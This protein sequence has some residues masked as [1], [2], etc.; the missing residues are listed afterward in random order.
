MEAAT[1]L[2]ELLLPPLGPDLDRFRTRSLAPL[3]FKTLSMRNWLAEHPGYAWKHGILWYKLDG[4]QLRAYWLIRKAIGKPFG[5]YILNWARR[6]GKT[7]ILLLIAIEE[8]IRIKNSRFNV[9]A[10]TKT[11]LYEFIWPMLRAMI[12]DC[13]DELKPKISQNHVSFEDRGGGYLVL[14]GCDDVEAVER[15]RGPFSHG[16]II[17]EGGT[18]PAKPGLAY[19]ITSILSPQLKSTRGWTLMAMTPPKSAGHASARMAIVAEAQGPLSYDYCTTF[20]CPRYDDADH[21]LSMKS[22]ADLL[23]ITIEEYIESVDFRRE[24]LALIETDPN[25]AIIRTFTPERRKKAVCDLDA[26]PIYVDRYV[27]MDIGFYPDFTAILYAYWSYERQKLRIVGERLIRRMGTIELKNAIKEDEAKFFGGNE[28]FLR[29]ADNN[30]KILV[31]DLAV[32]HGLIFTETAKDDLHAAVANVNMW[33]GQGRI[34][35]DPECKQLVAQMIAGTWNDKGTEFERTAEFGHFD[36]IASLVYLVR[37]VIPNVNR[38]PRM[39]GI[40][41]DHE[42]A[43]LERDDANEVLRSFFGV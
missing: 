32:D 18:I 27:S 25:Y 20:D 41:E 40:T 33:V 7:F 23:G 39:N 15:L 4:N 16:N 5:R 36:L 2:P 1:Q 29:V 26:V 19:L 6:T 10:S 21:R 24:W 3:D 9:A 30:N 37:N 31:K 43:N 13:P 28:P 12:A 17:E 35:I 14:A 34:E 38:V 8:A 22:D 11:S 42:V